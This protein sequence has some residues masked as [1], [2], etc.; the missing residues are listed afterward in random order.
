MNNFH[1]LF[2]S[3]IHQIFARAVLIRCNMFCFSVVVT[4]LLSNTVINISHLFAANLKNVSLAKTT[5]IKLCIKIYCNIKLKRFLC[6]SSTLCIFYYSA[7]FDSMNIN[8]IT[9]LYNMSVVGYL[10]VHYTYL[11]LMIKLDIYFLYNKE[12]NKIFW[13]GSC[14]LCRLVELPL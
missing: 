6:N 8:S 5:A 3:T 2:L 12:N 11:F 13:I 14:F 9:L 10:H 7:Y 4:D 1:E